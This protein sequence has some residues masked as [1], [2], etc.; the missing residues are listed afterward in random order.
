MVLYV[1]S[2]KLEV[3]VPLHHLQTHRISYFFFFCLSQVLPRRPSWIHFL[4]LADLP[5]LRHMYLQKEG[6]QLLIK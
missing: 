2:L 6:Q 1:L 3:M 4:P 5:V